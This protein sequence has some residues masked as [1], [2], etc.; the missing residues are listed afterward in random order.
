MHS[1]PAKETRLRPGRQTDTWQHLRWRSKVAVVKRPSLLF[2]ALVLGPSSALALAAL[3]VACSSSSTDADPGPTSGEA[4]LV[5]RGRLPQPLHPPASC[6]VTIDTP[7]L[8]P[9]IHVP[10]GTIIGYNSNPPSSGQHY[11]V[12]A[13][14]QE[15]TSP[16]EDGYLVHDLEHGAILLLYKCDPDAATCSPTIEAFRKVRD[17]I[18]TDPACEPDI[19]VRVVIAPYPKMDVPVAAVAWGWTY[20]AECV[21]LPTLTQFAKDHYGQGTEP[22]CS[23][24]RAF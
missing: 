22:Y 4:G 11:P 18:P 15:Y 8:L 7:E 16:I 17:A 12:W 10:E 20:K 6:P 5:D 19:R 21:D 1:S 14:F 9:G 13:N 23:R 2:R 24:G 3:V